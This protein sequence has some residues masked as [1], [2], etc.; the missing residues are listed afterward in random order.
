MNDNE[1]IHEIL[2][3]KTYLFKDI[4]EKYRQM[5]FRTCMGFTHNEED[6]GDLTQEVFINAYQNLKKFKGQS[7]FSTWLY[8]IAINAS[9]N[10]TRKI[11]KKMFFNELK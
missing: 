8:K 5:V 11:K 7:A 4:V 2:S 1:L 10:F 3:G 9:L 6:A